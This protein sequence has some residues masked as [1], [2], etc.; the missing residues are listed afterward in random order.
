MSHTELLAPIDAHDVAAG[1]PAPAMVFDDSATA[2]YKMFV[3]S[4]SPDAV[5]LDEPEGAELSGLTSELMP[6]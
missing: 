1:S 4:K 5:P 6:I 3:A 2:A